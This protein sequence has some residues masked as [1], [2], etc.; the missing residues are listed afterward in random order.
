MN[1]VLRP[2]TPVTFELNKR[3]LLS[4]PSTHTTTFSKKTVDTFSFVLS[5]HQEKQH[6]QNINSAAQR[7]DIVT[8]LSQDYQCP[9]M[10]DRNTG[11]E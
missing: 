10:M 4:T 3:R 5:P 11:L 8:S 7:L 6:K 1:L 9:S 2:T